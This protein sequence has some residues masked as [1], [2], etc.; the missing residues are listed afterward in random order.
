[1]LL[2]LKQY[3]ENWKL[4]YPYAHAHKT[5]DCIVRPNLTKA[6]TYIQTEHRLLCRKVMYVSLSALWKGQILHE[7]DCTQLVIFSQMFLTLLCPWTSKH[8][9]LCRLDK[10]RG[11][12]FPVSIISWLRAS[13]SVF[14]LGLY[15]LYACMV[16]VIF[17]LHLIP[18]SVNLWWS[19]WHV[20]FAC[21]E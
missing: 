5:R 1:M 12:C 2:A 6:I 15:T 8:A 20:L 16:T 21:F 3:F 13:K 10:E 18:P 7:T 19:C 4:H 17:H 9:G 14:L 11:A